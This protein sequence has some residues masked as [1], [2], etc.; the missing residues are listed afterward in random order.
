MTWNARTG[1]AFDWAA[2]FNSEMTAAIL[3][4][5]P[6]RVIDYQSRGRDA[7]LS[8]PTP[9]HFWPLLYVLGAR[10]E[11]DA[12]RLTT[13]VIEYGSLGMTSLVLTPA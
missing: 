7:A 6:G 1:P 3:A 13:D 5:Q 2:R 8:V 12:A 4:D 11:G 9:D 10:G